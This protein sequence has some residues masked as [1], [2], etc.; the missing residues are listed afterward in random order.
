MWTIKSALQR[1]GRSGSDAAVLPFEEIACAGVPAGPENLDPDGYLSANPDV[2]RS[3]A[4]PLAHY[5]AYGR[6]EGREL[7]H[8]RADVERVRRNKLARVRFSLHAPTFKSGARNFLSAELIADFGIPDHP[9]VSGHPYSGALISE[10]RAHPEN[11]YLDLGAGLRRTYYSNVVNAEIYENISTDILCVGEDLPFSDAL[12][13]GVFAFAVLEHT[14]RPWIV[15]KEICRV[16]KP[17]GKIIIDWPFLQAVHGYPHHYYNA[18]QEGNRRMFPDLIHIESVRVPAHQTPIF[19]LWWLLQ[20]WVNGLL[21]LDAE[22]FRGITVGE[23]LGRPPEAHLVE[24]YCSHLS[25]E[26]TAIIPAGTTL[27]GTRMR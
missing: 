24:P 16:L 11:L 1:L 18:T 2:L 23:L 22:Q 26:M 4:D 6:G 7:G 12:F 9:P 20:N 27:T 19:S 8:N 3:G 14:V 5:C 17:G 10:F 15:A 21:P 13:D 25:P